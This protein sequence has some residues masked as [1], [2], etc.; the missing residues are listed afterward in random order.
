MRVVE[1]MCASVI[2]AA[3]VALLTAGPQ[4]WTSKAPAQVAKVEPPT[5]SASSSLTWLRFPAMR[6]ATTIQ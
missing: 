2:L 1:V 4:G 5:S 6:R 3:A